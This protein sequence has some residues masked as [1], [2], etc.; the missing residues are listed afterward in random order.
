MKSLSDYW[1]EY[2]HRALAHTDDMAVKLALALTPIRSV[3]RVVDDHVPPF[4]VEY[5]SVQGGKSVS[6]TDFKNGRIVINPLPILESGPEIGSALDVVIGFAMHEASHGKHSRDRYRDLVVTEKS[7][8]GGFF[9]ER[10]V[11]AFRPMRLA[12]YLWNLAEDVRIEY[13]TS[14]SWPGFGPYFGAV[15]DYMWSHLDSAVQGGEAEDTPHPALVRALRTVYLACRYQGR[16]RERLD[17]SEEPEVEWWSAWQADYLHGRADTKTTIQRGL[18]HLAQDPETKAEMET[19]TKDEKKEEAAGER[20]RAQIERLV[21][22]GINGAYGVC[23]TADGEIVPLDGEIAERVDRL[24]REGLIESVPIRPANG[25]SNPPLHIRKPEE[26]SASRRAYIG[27]PDAESEALR[28]ALVF[29]SSV[30]QFD[31]KLLRQG[32]LDDEELYRWGLGDYRVYS[33]RIIEAKP[34]V[35]MGLL[36]DMSGSMAGRH[37]AIA[38]RLAQLFVWALHDQ[39]GVTTQVWGHTGD[40]VKDSTVDLFRLWERGDPMSR[41]GLIET[42]YH[43]NNYDGHAIAYC[44]RQ[45]MDREEPQRVLFVL[46]DGLPSGTGYGGERGMRHMREVN[47]WARREGVEVIQIAIDDDLR[48]AEQSLMFGEGNWIPYISAAA[49]PR[50]LARLMARWT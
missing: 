27:R 50:Q 48:P 10:E 37:L 46:S 19:L 38:Q 20:I 30:P 35:F 41:L 11:P 12:C 6:Y 33:E 2:T 49:L 3:V 29:R 40:T 32:V 13:E 36:V 15:L 44:V 16:W 5:A 43:A 9:R 45:L 39:E 17:A 42:L 28:A 1:A 24:V 7:N 23:V 31:V 25:A 26:A 18:D 4:S 21:K 47:E 34:D 22:E 14:K 8:L